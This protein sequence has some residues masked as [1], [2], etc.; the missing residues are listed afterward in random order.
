MTALVSFRTAAPARRRTLAASAGAL[1]AG[2]CLLVTGCSPGTPTASSAPGGAVV[3]GGVGSGTAASGGGSAVHAPAVAGP[4]RAAEQRSAAAGRSAPT[5]RPVTF[6]GLAANQD[7]IR[8]AS[9]T[10]QTANVAATAARATGIAQSAGGYVS[11]EHSSQSRDKHARTLVTIQFKVP[12]AGYQTALTAL[13][14]LGTKQSETQSAQDVTQTVA[15]VTSR[16]A[17]ARAAIVQ[18]RR[19]LAHAGTVSGLLTVQEQINEQEAG[20]EALQ[21]QQRALAAETTFATISMVIES[22]ARV[23]HK[24]HHKKPG[25]AGFLGGLTAGWHALRT[26]VAALLTFAGAVLPFAVVAALLAAAG[27]VTRRRIT[28]RRAGASPAR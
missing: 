11:A 8:T 6:P 20:L 15:D 22:P 7:L 12:P 9:L 16:V 18:L 3:N 21:S 26:V 4:A 23:F 25:P 17:S 10:V 5:G 14:G 24:H 28:R 1:T 13:A 19:L 27:L 2:A